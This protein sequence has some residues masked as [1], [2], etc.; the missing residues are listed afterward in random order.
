LV[1]RRTLLRNAALLAALTVLGAAGSG[2]AEDPRGDARAHYARGLELAAQNGYEGALR[3]FNEAYTISP[4]Y[5]VLYN[6]G[7]AH[8]A[9]GHTA[10]AIETLGRYLRDG[11]DRVTPARR[12]QVERQIAWLRSARGG[13]APEADKERATGAAAGEASSVAAETA[14]AP[15]LPAPPTGTLTVR[16]NDPALRL[17]LDGKHLDPAAATRGVAVPAGTRRLVMSSAGRRTVEQE[18]TISEGTA[19][20]VICENVAPTSPTGPAFV[21]FVPAGP[22]PVAVGPPVFSAITANAVTPIIHARTVGYLL[23]GL[24]LAVGGTAIGLYVWNR[25][26]AEHAQAEYAALPPKSDPTFHDLALQYNQD[27]DGVRSYANLT[28]GLA[29]ASIGLVAGSGYLLWREHR[30]Q[31]KT[32]QASGARSWATLVPGGAVLNGVW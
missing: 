17:T 2:R 16:C 6:I 32:G 20:V 7:Q 24:G 11:G 31:M 10:E 14:Q 19:T 21:P 28:I 23:G 30:R 1:T 29:V 27:A 3:E 4:Q 25:G 13:P 5:A 12:A 26:Q 9:L 22:Q 8:I 15:T 18:V